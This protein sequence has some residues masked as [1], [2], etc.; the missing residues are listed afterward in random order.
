MDMIIK[1]S[2][3]RINM[4]S[5]M[6]KIFI[7][8][9]R[10]KI[11]EPYKDIILLSMIFLLVYGSSL[12][13]WNIPIQGDDFNFAYQVNHLNVELDQF[14]E[15]NRANI[16]GILLYKLYQF[17][18][19]FKTHFSTNIMYIFYAIVN[20]LTCILTYFFIRKGLSISLFKSITNIPFWATLIL[21]VQQPAIECYANGAFGYRLCSGIFV[22]LFL[23]NQLYQLKSISII[24]MIASIF[25]AYFAI[26]FYEVNAFF[27]VIGAAF[28][29]LV[30]DNN[31][32]KKW[33]L[34][35]SF[36]ITSIGIPVLIRINNFAITINE[37]SKSSL[38]EI[39]DIVNRFVYYIFQHILPNLRGG[40]FYASI[41]YLITLTIIF[42]LFIKSLN[43]KTKPINI[44]AIVFGVYM[45]S[46]VI[47]ISFL[48]Y[49]APRLLYTNTIFYSLIIAMILNV[50][51]AHYTKKWVNCLAIM[52]IVSSIINIGHFFILQNNAY[53]T[54]IAVKQTLEYAEQ[55]NSCVNIDIT[56]DQPTAVKLIGNHMRD[57]T[58]IY[59]AALN[60]SPM[61]HRVVIYNNFSNINTKSNMIT[62]ISKKLWSAF[63]SG[64][65][66][67]TSIILNKKRN[68]KQT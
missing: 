6:N 56:H 9:S 57:I 31:T 67:N 26:S 38:P 29:F 43:Q 34:Y 51:S 53:K 7:L 27:L 24:R 37:K 3:S 21:M 58:N 64:H 4:K 25:L 2:I 41:P 18:A 66:I 59:T 8:F 36:L 15:F 52:L 61:C 12:L 39:T 49:F 48:P 5:Q 45:C 55:Q 54:L 50:I 33:Y 17:M 13:F 20:Y 44:I 63:N 10:L 62:N 1:S 19:I 68:N 30:K 35:Y 16:P 23:I 22:I 65:Y 60:I 32:L 42:V 46:F 40:I 47:I 14:Y 11:Q 28:P